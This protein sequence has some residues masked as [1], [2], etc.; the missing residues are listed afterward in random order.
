[1][2]EILK[3]DFEHTDT[4]GRLVQ[5][6]HE[7]YE[8]VNVLISNHE[9]QR[10]DHYHKEVREAFYIISG[11]VFLTAKREEQTQ[12]Y[13]FSAGDFFE[14]E[15]YT[16]HSMRFPEHCVMVQM[17]SKSVER[18]DGTKDI[19]TVRGG[20]FNLWINTQEYALSEIRVHWDRQF[21]VSLRLKVMQI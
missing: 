15:P 10:G 8:Q 5:L 14:I 3:T 11:S 19:H 16:I 18:S 21:A 17:Y 12:E 20:Q 13:Y 9:A 6:A 7:G 4:R 1:M 2:V